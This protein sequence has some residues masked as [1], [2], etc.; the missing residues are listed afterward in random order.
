MIEEYFTLNN[1]VSLAIGVFIIIFALGFYL[2]DKFKP[3]QRG[4][5]MAVSFLIASIASWQLYREKYYGW[6][7]ILVFIFAAV[8]LILFFKIFW[9]FVKH[10]QRNF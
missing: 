9:S 8:A 6:E 4:T 2:L 7:G 10:W 1:P 3:D 5:M